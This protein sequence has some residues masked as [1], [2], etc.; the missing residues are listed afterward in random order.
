M[1]KSLVTLSLILA[2]LTACEGTPRAEAAATSAFT[3]DSVRQAE[4]A[5]FRAGLPQVYELEGGADSRDALAEKVVAA[6]ASRDTAVVRG[7]VL[8]RAEYAWLYYPATPQGRPPYDLDPATLWLTLSA[9][10]ER[11][12]ARAMERLGDR[13]VSFLGSSCQGT[14]SREGQN[15]VYGPCTVRLVVAPHDTSEGRLFGLV[16]ERHGRWKLVSYANRLD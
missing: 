12:V 6:I 9:Q 8:S 11:G 10:S 5:R 3:P 16:I 14:P 1:S 2:G 15:T 13:S 7:L 4:L